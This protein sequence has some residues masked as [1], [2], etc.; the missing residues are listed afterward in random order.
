VIIVEAALRRAHADLKVAATPGGFWPDY[1]TPPAARMH[2]P[3]TP[4]WDGCIFSEIMTEEWPAIRL[5]FHVRASFVP[6]VARVGVMEQVGDSRSSIMLLRRDD[7]V[8]EAN[9]ERKDK[10]PS[11]GAR[12]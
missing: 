3:P 10:G 11:A 9:K 8:M 5:A 2:A 4:A 6:T 12:Y 7:G 1:C